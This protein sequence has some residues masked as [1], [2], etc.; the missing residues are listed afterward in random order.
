MCV[1]ISRRLLIT[2]LK[3]GENCYIPAHACRHIAS[4]CRYFIFI[5][6]S[7]HVRHGHIRCRLDV[8]LSLTI[9]L[10]LIGVFGE[11]DMTSFFKTRSTTIEED[12]HPLNCRLPPD[13]STCTPPACE[14]NQDCLEYCCPNNKD[15]KVCS[16]ACLIESSKTCCCR[17]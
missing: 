1:Y 17:G 15:P 8:F 4:F 12:C 14:H 5:E 3:H 7:F 10:F 13:P 9:V 11:S 2:I 6:F 16:P